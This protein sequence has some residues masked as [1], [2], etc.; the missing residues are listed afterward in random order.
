[1]AQD[2]ALPYGVEV[3]Q[4]PCLR[5]CLTSYVM[6]S[7]NESSCS[8][9]DKPV[10]TAAAYL[11]LA[12]VKLALSKYGLSEAV[13]SSDSSCMGEAAVS[14]AGARLLLGEIL[15]FACPPPLLVATMVALSE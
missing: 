8:V 13:K 11:T 10:A 3:T 12:P 15:G 9:A 4:P 7:C 14:L 1:M 2:A 6:S 5:N